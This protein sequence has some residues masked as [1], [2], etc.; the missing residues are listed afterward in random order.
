MTCSKYIHVARAQQSHSEW[1]SI[2]YKLISITG[3]E[4][5]QYLV[6]STYGN[7]LRPTM[8]SALLLACTNMHKLVLFILCW[9][10][11]PLIAVA[12]AESDHS[13]V[14]LVSLLTRSISISLHTAS[15]IKTR[16]HSTDTANQCQSWPIKAFANVFE[17]SWSTDGVSTGDT[18]SKIQFRENNEKPYFSVLKAHTELQITPT[19]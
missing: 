15:S 19:I 5:L 17:H 14:H 8:E 13:R 3:V 7:C 10:K 1:H 18:K 6:T 12:E 2:K 9:R 4:P 11:W 16:K